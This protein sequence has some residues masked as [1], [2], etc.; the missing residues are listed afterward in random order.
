MSC[1]WTIV[2]ERRDRISSD[3]DAPRN[4]RKTSR[5]LQVDEQDNSAITMLLKF[6]SKIPYL[7]KQIAMKII[8][9]FRT[10]RISS[11]LIKVQLNVPFNLTT[12]QLRSVESFYYF[13]NVLQ[14]TAIGGTPS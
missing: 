11:L 3:R 6:N 1:G 2:D 7:C 14:A 8:I 10:I 4:R 9:R 13:R 5:E 12:D